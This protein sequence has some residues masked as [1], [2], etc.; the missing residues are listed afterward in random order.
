MR[1]YHDICKDVGYNSDKESGSH[2][3][4]DMLDYFDN[5]INYLCGLFP[6]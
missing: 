2:N 1:S 3:P 5:E 6:R 4:D